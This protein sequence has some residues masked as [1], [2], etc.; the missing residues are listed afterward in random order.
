MNREE[1]L[2][3]VPYLFSLILSLGVFI[4]TWQHRQVRGARVYS[5]FVGGQTLTIIG[6][7]FELISPNIETK[8]LWDKFQWITDSYLVILPFLIFSYQYSEYKFRHP[9]LAWGYWIGIPILFTLI[10]LTDNTHHLLYPNLH[11]ST[12]FPFPDL[13]Y[14]FT[15]IVYLYAL[16]YIY[17]ANFYGIGLLVRRAVQPYNPYRLQYW[18]IIIGFLIP[19]VFSIFS[20]LGIRVAP[21][22][23][24]SPFTFAIGNIVVVWGLF[25]YGL[26]DIIPIARE[27]VIENM[28]DPVVVLDSRN[29]VVDINL[30]ALR[31][32]EKQIADVL[33]ESSSKVFARWP[34]IANELDRLDTGRKEIAVE[35]D[36]DTFFFDLNISPL[37]NKNGQLLG[38]IVA[39]RDVTRHKTLEAGYRTL[40]TELEERIKE[41][42]DEL[43]QTAERYRA[44][45]ENQTEFIV[46]WKPDRTRIFVNDAYCRH[47]GLTYEQAMQTDFLTLIAE[48]DRPAIE[49][50]IKRLSSG[51]TDVETEIHRAINPNGSIAW[52]EWTDQVIRDETGKLI[53]FLSVG[54][55]I[56][57]RKQA[58]DEIRKLSLAVEESNVSIVITNNTGN[59]E[60]VNPYFSEL[61]GYTAD[62][63]IGKSPRILQS[64]LTPKSVYMGLWKMITDGKEW[65]GEF[66]NRKKDGELYWESASISPI[67]DD[68]NKI[69]HYVA[70]KTDITER[71]QSEQIIL[72]QLAFDE[73]LTRL[74]RDFATCS[75]NEVD[76][77]IEN[78]LKEVATFLNCD[79]I[80][81]LLLS[82]DNKSWVSTHQWM[83]P[84][85]T[86]MKHPVHSI[87]VGELTWSE[88]KLLKGESIR[89]SSLD[90]YPPEAAAD[91][92]FSEEEGVKSL[93]SV[94]IK[95]RDH[96]VAGVIDAVSYTHQVAWPSSDI[97]HLKIIGDSIANVLERKRT[98]AAQQKSEMKHR[99]LFES[100]NDSIFIMKE[101]QFID[102]NSKTLE[103]FGCEREQIIGKTPIDFSPATQPDGQ[104]SIEKADTKINAVLS[105]KPQFFEWKHCQ[106]DGTEFDAEVSLSLL[107]LDNEMFIQAI[108]RDTTE[109]K[110]SEKALQL[111]E[112]RFSKAFRSSPT[113][114]VISQISNAKILEVNE[115]FEKVTGFSRNE[116]VGRNIFDLGFW[117]NPAER[118]NLRSTLFERGQIRNIE[119]PFR[120]KNG[121]VLTCLLSAEL[122]ELDGEAC[123]LA[124][125]EDISERKKAEERILRL[126]RLYVT[127]SQINQTI[128]HARDKAN[129]FREICR[130]VIDHGKFRMAWIGLIDETNEHVEPMVFAGEELDYLKDLKINWTNWNSNSQKSMHHLS[131]YRN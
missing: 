20:L 30:A 85:L 25:R 64:G 26:F 8:L 52:Q 54:R 70:V 47:F 12:D 88:N 95:G 23:D 96:S 107:E 84:Q 49:E 99:L 91:R 104:A 51:K 108:V 44:V 27:H 10:L 14:S 80:D 83:S 77:S 39:A 33:G 82:E 63:V 6:F 92:Q 71:K 43:L 1:I 98:E 65:R 113:I 45:V 34:L 79:F 75:Y 36:G 60:Y 57:K 37:H 129:L 13:Q 61:T 120:I 7:I 110:K 76:A 29:R 62:E 32:L 11:L 100:A 115:T 24:F 9:R 40:S 111:S 109:R 68:N 21:Q 125:I 81:I 35:Q 78:A 19:F 94:P 101:N 93:L 116:V 4:Y 5:W 16:L 128:V 124:T 72:S 18:T 15:Y 22:R 41:R 69:T 103:M 121:I 59:I 28:I 53:E 56:T 67:I 74:L 90:D 89:I 55:D 106:L 86:S 105:G 48:E 131:R 87:Q 127:I 119:L 50:K 130:V 112:E 102:C 122:I 42:T 114:I 66:C 46:R 3:L 17:G 2:Y 31:L 73:L 97:T 38:R 118:D 58:E 123:I 126:N 117:V